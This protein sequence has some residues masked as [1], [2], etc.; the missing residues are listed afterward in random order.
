[1]RVLLKYKQYLFIRNGL[2][3]WKVKLKNHDSKISQFILP[4]AHRCPATLALHDD[5]GHLGMEKTLGLLQEWFFRPKM[6]EDVRNHIRTC[7][8]CTKYKQQPE[9]EK[10]KPIHCTYPLELVHLDFLT[11]GKEGTE[12]AIDLMVITD[13][14]TRY[15]QAYIT[16]KQTVLMVAK[17]LWDQFLVHYG[18]PTK[19]L[20][21][22]GNSF[23]NQLIRELCSLAQVQK[24][25]TTPYKPQTNGSC[26]HFN[27]TL[28]S[29]LGTL[30]IHA[31]KNWPEWV[32]T[33]THRY[34]ATMCHATRFSPFFLMYGRIPILPIDVEFGVMIPDITHAS[35]QN[36]AEK[37]KAHLKWPCKV[38][39]ENSDREAASHKQFY[40]QKFKCMKIV[41]GDLVLVRIKAFGPDHKIADRWEQVPYKVL[42]QHDNS[43][44]YKV[45]PVNKN[46]EENVRTLHRNMLFPL[47][48]I[49]ENETLGQNEALV[50][51]D[52]AMMSYFLC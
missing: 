19:I 34:N 31:K 35:H 22:Q 26:K 24:L 48:S 23:E 33:L 40:D 41:P 8:L 9:R 29:M 18:W 28:M 49:R 45:Q 3:Y 17:T 52:L 32:S 51:V 43:P 20:M 25:Q 4:K 44:V 50:Q 6:I 16:P 13:H 27:Y 47:Q 30:P 14:F 36:Y 7:K 39:R 12:K 15:V 46:T 10:L 38:V 42:S 11:I 37:L 5:Y 2:L 21:D 1:M